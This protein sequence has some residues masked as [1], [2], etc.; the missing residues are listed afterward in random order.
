MHHQA[1]LFSAWATLSL[2]YRW[3]S[4]TF[5]RNFEEMEYDSM[6]RRRVC[7][8][9][10]RVEGT[11]AGLS[12]CITR[13]VYSLHGPLYLW[14]IDGHHKHLIEIL[15]RWSTIQCKDEEY[16]NPLF[17]LKELLPDFRHASPG[18]FILCLGHFIS[19]ISMVITNI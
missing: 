6:Q 2:A 18:K 19:G 13:Q 4:Q 1:S 15:R 3:S 11:T 7:E 17:M 16:V 10:V 9:I 12:A 5:N 8:S 14:H